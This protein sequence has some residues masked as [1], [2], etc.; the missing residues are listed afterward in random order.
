MNNQQGTLGRKTDKNKRENRIALDRQ[1]FYPLFETIIL[2]MRTF[3]IIHIILF[4]LLMLAYQC[5]H[6]Q[7][8]AVTIKGDTLRGS[9]K[10]LTFG[11]DKKLQV[12]EPGKKKVSYPLF[13]IKS[14]VLDGDTYIP[15]KGPSGYT[16]MRVLKSGFLSL[17]AYQVENQVTFDGRFLL[18]KTGAGVEVPNLSFKKVLK[19]FLSDC[20]DISSRIDTGELTRKDL[21]LIIDLYNQCVD[22][23]VA[24]KKQVVAVQKERVE[25][26]NPWDE[27]QNKI[28]GAEEFEGKKDALDM[29]AEIK[30]KISKGEKIPNFMVEGLKSALKAEAF[31]PYLEAALKQLQ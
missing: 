24:T 1:T 5:A 18:K 20:G 23:I 27:L 4:L 25:K 6:A 22:G 16:F 28:Q 3:S 8:Y 15:A 10:P 7:D 12:A 21:D 14:F 26:L 30:G 19:T 31:Q 9:L 29:I 2:T 11:P 13:Q 17:L